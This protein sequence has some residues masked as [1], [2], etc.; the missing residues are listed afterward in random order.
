MPQGPDSGI[1]APT[2]KKARQ[3]EGGQAQNTQKFDILISYEIIRFRLYK[4]WMI[5]SHY[6]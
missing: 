5:L 2:D 1:Y 6:L 4:K 3:K